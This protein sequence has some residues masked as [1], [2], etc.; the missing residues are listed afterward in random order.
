LPKNW[1]ITTTIKCRLYWF[2][3]NEASHG[4]PVQWQIGI[5]AIG[6]GEALAYNI[7]WNN[8]HDTDAANDVLYITDEVAITPE[9]AGVLAPCDMLNIIVR[10]NQD[11]ASGSALLLGILLQYEIDPTIAV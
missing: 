4:T 2:V 10:R 5:R 3:T 7:V 8:N 1:K 6:D 11:D 9:K